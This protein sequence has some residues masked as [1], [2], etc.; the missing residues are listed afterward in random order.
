MRFA[1]LLYEDDADRVAKT[2]D[3]VAEC[4]AY[5]GA[6][7]KAGILMGGERLR[8]ADEAVRVRIAAGRTQVLDGPYVEAKEQLGGLH[9]IDVPD[10]DAALAWAARAPTARNGRVEVRPLWTD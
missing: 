1:L 2:A 6:M 9:L 3:E 4:I 8:P 7:E 5:A 10:L